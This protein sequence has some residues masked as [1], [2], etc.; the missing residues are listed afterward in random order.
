[1]TQANG[2]FG[3]GQPVRILAQTRGDDDRDRDRDRA[4]W[5][6][7]SGAGLV[8]IAIIAVFIG[9]LGP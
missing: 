1:M 9:L 7:F 3:V 8:V 5:S 4:I 2:G 6:A